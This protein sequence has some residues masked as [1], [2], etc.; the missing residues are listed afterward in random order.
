MT[1]PTTSTLAVFW[2]KW[3]S[4]LILAVRSLWLHKLRSILSVLG[5]IIGTAAVIALMAFGIM[6]ARAGGLFF[7]RMLID[8]LGEKAVA[9]AQRDMFGR[10]IRRASDRG[11]FVLLDRQ[12]PSRLM[13]AFPPGV[14]V[15]RVGLAR[16]VEETGAFLRTRAFLTP[17][18]P[19]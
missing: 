6:T 17:G 9:Q 3:R 19:A 1:T 2:M 8:S 18:S 14:V 16:A 10:L 12:A 11:V 5:I 13:S 7:G 15:Q 4:S